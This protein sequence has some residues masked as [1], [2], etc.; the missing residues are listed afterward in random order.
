MAKMNAK[1]PK[2]ETITS[3]GENEWQMHKN[4][5]YLHRQVINTN[6]IKT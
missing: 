1:K 4:I 2:N 6:G 3:N 5:Q